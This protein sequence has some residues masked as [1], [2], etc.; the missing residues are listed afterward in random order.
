MRY[1]D[2]STGAA[3]FYENFE[4]VEGLKGRYFLVITD[5]SP[6]FECFTTTTQPHAER[7][8]KLATEFCELAQ[9]ECCLPKRCFVDFRNIYEFD[10]IQ[11]NSWLRSGRVKHLGDLPNALL[12]RLHTAL[13][14]CRSMAPIKKIRLLAFLQARI[15]CSDTAS[16]NPWA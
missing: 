4:G 15:E 10:D 16:G 7:N 11:L 2:L 9:G 12:K 5:S 6:A 13:S 3:I 8:P 1:C 14:G